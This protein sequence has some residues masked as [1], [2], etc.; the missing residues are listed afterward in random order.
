MRRSTI[1]TIRYELCEAVW[2]E[3]RMINLSPPNKHEWKCIAE[4]FNTMYIFCIGN[5]SIV[6]L[7][8]CDANYIFKTVD[9][10]AYGSQSDGDVLW[11]SGFG[12]RLLSEDLPEDSYLPGICTKFPYF[13]RK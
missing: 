10:G 4:D 6:L 13:M 12:Q 2:E 11:H 9:I 8:C 1:T 7:A 5:Y 3:L